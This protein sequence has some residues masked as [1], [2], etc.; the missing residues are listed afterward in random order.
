MNTERKKINR[1][2]SKAIELGSQSSQKF[3]ELA[4][5]L[6]D[7]HEQQAISI[8]EYSQKTNISRRRIYYLIDVGNLIRS[9]K[10]DKS[11]AEKVGW[12][13]L[14]ILTRHLQ[15][16]DLDSSELKASLKLAAETKVRDLPAALEGRSQSDTS[17][18]VFHL[19]KTQQ[20]KL[21][22][23]LMSFG[24]TKTRSGLTNKEVALMRMIKQAKADTLD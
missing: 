19:T 18:E 3:Y 15:H 9:G 17:G 13:K 2:R 12:T 7:L 21:R 8:D 5:V 16:N 11:I 10:I 22:R 14:R 20:Q 4:L 6:A 24:A 1:S 23:A